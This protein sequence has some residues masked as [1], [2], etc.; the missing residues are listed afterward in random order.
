MSA[1]PTYW[2]RVEHHTYESG[3]PPVGAKDRRGQ[4]RDSHG[5]LF[6]RL[7][8]DEIVVVEGGGHEAPS[9]IGGFID[10]RAELSPGDGIEQD[11][12]AQLPHHLGRLTQTSLPGSADLG[13]PGNPGLELGWVPGRE[14]Q[15]VRRRQ[16]E[17]LTLHHRR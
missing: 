2:V 17:G 6:F 9:G 4:Q 16:R 7:H 1:R 10:G 15:S 12:V 13:N 11:A 8:P 3:H 5:T 14:R